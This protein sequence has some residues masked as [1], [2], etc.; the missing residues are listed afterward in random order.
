MIDID[1]LMINLSE[2]SHQQQDIVVVWLYGSYAKGTFHDGSDVDLAIAFGDFS[3]TPLERML[4]TEELK[5]LWATQLQLPESKLSLVDINTIPSYL[6][7]NVIEYGNVIVSKDKV[8]ELKE[9]QRI[10]SQFEFACI[11]ANYG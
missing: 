5:L 9:I 10:Y 6:A 1:K 7:F 4:R 2:L 11:E 3:L 8:R